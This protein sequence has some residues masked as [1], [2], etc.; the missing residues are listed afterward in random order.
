MRYKYFYSYP[1]RN[2][3]EK[4]VR[5]VHI[6]LHVEYD[7]KNDSKGESLNFLY[8]VICKNHYWQYE[9]TALNWII[10]GK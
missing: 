10:I 2:L 5:K 1:D 9:E 6:Y 8:F 7:N 4:N 3:Y